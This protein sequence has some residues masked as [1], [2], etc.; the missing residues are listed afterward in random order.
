[1]KSCID[2][3][4]VTK[5]LWWISRQATLDDTRRNGSSYSYMSKLLKLCLDVLADLLDECILWTFKQI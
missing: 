5:Q 3:N 2:I 1:M 4:D